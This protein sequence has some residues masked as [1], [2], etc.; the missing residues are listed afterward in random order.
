MYGTVE[1]DFNLFKKKGVV[2]IYS[3]S[4]NLSKW[5]FKVKN[6]CSSTEIELNV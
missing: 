5:I 6:V 3:T 2:N 4:R 1:N